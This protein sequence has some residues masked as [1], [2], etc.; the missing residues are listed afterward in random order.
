MSIRRL[1]R[2]ASL[3]LIVL[4]L[5]AG[6]SVGIDRLVGLGMEDPA[7]L[8]GLIFPPHSEVSMKTSE[9]DFTAYIN[10]IGLRGPAP[11]SAPGFFRIAAIG[12]SF[13][14]GW[15]VNYEE[16]W[17]YQLSNTLKCQGK[18]VEIL[19]LGSPGSNPAMYADVAERALSLLQP[20]LVV[21]AVVQTDD[22]LCQ[23]LTGRSAKSHR[24]WTRQRIVESVRISVSDTLRTLYPNLMTLWRPNARKPLHID[25]AAME[26]QVKKGIA[27][28][29]RTIGPEQRQ[30]FE[31]LPADLR[32]ALQSG[33][34]AITELD[35][36][37]YDP[38]F[39]QRGLTL[40]NEDVQRLIIEMAHHFGRIRAA[41]AAVNAPVLVLSIPPAAYTQSQNIDTLRRLGFTTQADFLRTQAPD[42][43]IQNAC[44]KG[45]VPFLSVTQHMRR[46]AEK[47]VL[48]FLHDA[49]FSPLGHQRFAE[50]LLRDLPQKL[51]QVL[52]GNVASL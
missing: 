14:Y 48:Y 34:M 21:V 51:L 22:L 41:A 9:Y 50:A 16:T 46:Y 17:L 33:D 1:C 45:G 43:A 25:K 26:K 31:A 29:M 47:D 5:I 12:D 52:P 11:Q 42:Q 19:N 23:S 13:T 36:L 40:E 15:G 6:V 39:W 10:E 32:Q 4:F 8:R 20:D 37:L 35:K 18:S 38:H 7:F 3:I 24:A 30:R 49:H 27:D 28:Y 2:D 44:Q